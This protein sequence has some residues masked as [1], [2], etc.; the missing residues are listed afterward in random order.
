MKAIVTE[1][2]VCGG[3][4]FNNLEEACKDYLQCLSEGID[5]EKLNFGITLPSGEVKH[6]TVRQEGDQIVAYGD[7]QGLPSFL[8]YAKR[9][10]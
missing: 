2:Q 6:I 4:I 7:F 1:V 8:N 10:H 9:G 3:R 5:R